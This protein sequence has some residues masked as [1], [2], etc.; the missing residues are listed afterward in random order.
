LAVP[1]VGTVSIDKTLIDPVM[2]I[3]APDG[4]CD[5]TVSV[6]MH[7]AIVTSLIVQVVLLPRENLLSEKVGDPAPT[8]AS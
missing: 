5:I 1:Y 3:V 6:N 2:C 7:A 8:K 4:D